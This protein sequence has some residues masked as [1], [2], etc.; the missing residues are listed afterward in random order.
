MAERMEVTA[1]RSAPKA[2]AHAG[3]LE[4]SPEM[5]STA[6]CISAIPAAESALSSS[7]EATLASKAG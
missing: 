4:N 2:T 3:H 1:A 5:A 6:F 7:P